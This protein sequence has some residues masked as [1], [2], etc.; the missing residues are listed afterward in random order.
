VYAQQKEVYG[1]RAEY[2]RQYRKQNPEYV[3]RNAAFVKKYRA[4]RQKAGIDPVSPTSCDL[5]LSVWN[6]TGNVSIT[7]VSHTSPDGLRR[8]LDV[9]WPHDEQTTTTTAPG[10]HSIY[11]RFFQL[12]RSSILPARIRPGIDPSG[13]VSTSDEA[14]R[15]VPFR[16]LSLEQ[17]LEFINEDELVEIT[18][19][20]IRLRKKT[21]HANRRWK[22]PALIV[23]LQDSM[24]YISG[25]RTQH[26]GGSSEPFSS[27]ISH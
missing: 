5:L 15:L 25:S 16:D 6:Q 11:P 1:T 2:K 17:A 4:S 3:R 14:I 8:R 9:V 12:D 18:P 21:L 24:W 7:H 23:W 10:S 19:K 22:Y 27:Q 26:I 20:S 13:K